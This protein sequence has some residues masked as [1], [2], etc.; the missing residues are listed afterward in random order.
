MLISIK[1]PAVYGIDMGLMALFMGLWCTSKERLWILMGLLWDVWMDFHWF[2]WMDINRLILWW[3]F[4]G[5]LMVFTGLLIGF[6]WMSNGF[7]W[8]FDGMAIYLCSI[9][10]IDGYVTDM[11]S[12]K[13][14]V[15]KKTE[16]TDLSR[17]S[18]F[19]SIWSP[20]WSWWFTE[21]LWGALMHIPKNTHVS[22]RLAGAM[23]PSWK[24]MDFVNGKDD[25]PFY[26][27]LWNEK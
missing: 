9:W 20:L 6:R 25:I 7:Q 12:I 5:M 1:S 24:M 16:M 23:C 2:L 14:W 17:F 13:K 4:N 11:C 10:S 8:K 22:H 26:P 27:F 18:R 15:S 21:S 19:L 3:D